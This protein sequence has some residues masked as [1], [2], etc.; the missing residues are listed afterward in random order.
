M[1]TKTSNRFKGKVRD[2]Y[3]ELVMAFPLAS[4]RSEDHLEEAQKVIDQL[5]A[6]GKLNY[7]EEMYLDAL[8]DL[9]ASYEDEHHPI[10]PASDADMLYHLMDAKGGKQ[11]QLSREAS[12]AKSTVSE[13]LAGKKVFTRKIIRKLADYGAVEVSMLSANL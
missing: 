8:S 13:V 4:V 11:A 3:L 7:G 12:I 9:V 6:K 2:A 5:L 10:A 1:A